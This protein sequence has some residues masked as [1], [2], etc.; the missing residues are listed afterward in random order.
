[1]ITYGYWLYTELLPILCRS[2]TREMLQTSNYGEFDVV[3]K[4]NRLAC[5][6]RSPKCVSCHVTGQIWA[7]QSHT[8]LGKRSEVSHEL[9]PHLNLY[10]LNRRDQMVL[11]TQDHIYPRSKGGSSDLTNLQTMCTNCN[12]AK[13]DKI[14][15]E[16]LSYRDSRDM[17]E[18]RLREQRFRALAANAD[19]LANSQKRS[20]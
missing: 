7:L 6:K 10:G 5:F 11:M 16:R 13:A 2:D 8:P 1:M 4:T 14:P 19:L 3:V 17:D 20:A 12:Q 18:R 15:D 9:R